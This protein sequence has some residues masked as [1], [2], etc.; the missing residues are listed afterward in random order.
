MN[1]VPLRAPEANENNTADVTAHVVFFFFRTIKKTSLYTDRLKVVE[2]SLPVC[3]ID[4]TVQRS[5][6]WPSSSYI[7]SF[8]FYVLKGFIFSFKNDSSHSRLSTRHWRLGC[9]RT[10][11]HAIEASEVFR[12]VSSSADLNPSCCN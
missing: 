10:Q 2:G 7:Q 1:G 3:K 5:G 8:V 9:K 6:I 12:Q 11:L 4:K